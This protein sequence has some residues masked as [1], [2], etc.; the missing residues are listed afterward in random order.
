MRLIIYT[1]RMGSE[2]DDPRPPAVIDPLARYLC[3]SDAPVDVAPYEWVYVPAEVNARLASR[4]LK[5]LADHP[6]LADADVTLWHDASYRL[7]QSA[8]WTRRALKRA[9]LTMMA[10]PRRTRIEDEAIAIARWGYLTPDAALALVAGYRA[11]GFTDNVLSASG[12]LG[13]KMSDVVRAFNAAWW[14]QV[15][16]WNGRDQAATDFAA[17]QV[18]AVV[19]HVPGAV[20]DNAFA[21]WRLQA[22]SA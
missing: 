8:D 19:K 3:F 14:N 6:A 17:W 11:A 1:A 16:C 12:L 15:L 20:R 13:R 21:A 18:G 5:C 9:D 2:S 22:V 7:L 4:R 10:H